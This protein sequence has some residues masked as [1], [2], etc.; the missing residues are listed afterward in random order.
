M[1]FI[2][3]KNSVDN[4][5]APIGA[6]TFLLCLASIAW[7]Q[8]AF[9]Q[10][11]ENNVT[12][13]IGSFDYP[14][15]SV[16]NTDKQVPSISET[17]KV[18]VVADVGLVDVDVKIDGTTIVGTFSLISRI[19]RQNDIVYGLIFVSEDGG[20]VNGLNLGEVP[21]LDEGQVRTESINV[22]I[23]EIISNEG[24]V[25]I[26]I[27]AETKNGLPLSSKTIGEIDVLST[28]AP[29]V[30]CTVGQDL[31]NTI[32]CEF[33]T[34][35]SGEMVFKNSLLE[36]SEIARF[37]V[38]GTVGSA[39]EFVVPDSVRG[40][41]YGVL[42]N[43]E[44][45]VIDVIRGRSQKDYA[46]FLNVVVYQSVE[47]LVLAAPIDLRVTSNPSIRYSLKD[48]GGAICFEGEELISRSVFT[49]KFPEN[50]GCQTG[51]VA[52]QIIDQAGI[53][54]D[55]YIS[56]FNVVNYNLSKIEDKIEADI[57]M[58][59]DSQPV[60]KDQFKHVLMFA[61]LAVSLLLFLGVFLWFKRKNK[62]EDL[63]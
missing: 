15:I 44:Q 59:D 62:I 56:T 61:G 32:L 33:L 19:G 63:K 37:T 41:Y 29:A 12:S 35:F 38:Q 43:S 13:E 52:V 14:D 27:V 22:K 40:N 57:E 4:P 51:T 8:I 45:Q 48:Q 49:L 36:K 28:Q 1:F 21:F 23:P 10:S 26:R 54:L 20:V 24:P 46:K 47:S 30:I 17:N 18:A 55:E 3:K 31:N 25:S 6:I 60:G 2:L 39:T 58:V 34:D 9:A 53:L 11:L 7:S 50:L 16:Q 5:A 42:L